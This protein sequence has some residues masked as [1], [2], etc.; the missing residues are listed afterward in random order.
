MSSTQILEF[1]GVA[2]S[3]WV[4]YERQLS[5]GFLNFVLRSCLRNTEDF[6]E[7]AIVDLLFGS[8]CTSEVT[9]GESTA[10][11]AEEHF[12]LFSNYLY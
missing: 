2:T 9:E 11:A 10:T 12:L 4:I 3:V 1:L 8:S 7:L 5:I 6:V